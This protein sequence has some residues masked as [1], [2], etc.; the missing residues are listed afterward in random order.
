MYLAVPSQKTQEKPKKKKREEHRAISVPEPEPTAK[1]DPPKPKDK[2]ANR[3]VMAEIG[4]A[5]TES[6]AKKRRKRA[7][8]RDT[9]KEYYDAFRANKS[10][11]FGVEATIPGEG[12]NALVNDT[13]FVTPAAQSSDLKERIVKEDGVASLAKSDGITRTPAIPRKRVLDIATVEA[14]SSR[15]L[16]DYVRKM[17]NMKKIK[18]PKAKN[19]EAIPDTAEDQVPM[20]AQKETLR[21]EI[22]NA[23]AVPTFTVRVPHTNPRLNSEAASPIRKRKNLSSPAQGAEELIEPTPF[24]TVRKKAK[25]ASPSQK[26]GM[27]EAVIWDLIDHNPNN[28]SLIKKL[29]RILPADSENRPERF[30]YTVGSPKVTAEKPAGSDSSGTE[31]GN[32]NGDPKARKKRPLSRTLNNPA[33]EALARENVIVMP[34]PY[35]LLERVRNANPSSGSGK[36]FISMVRR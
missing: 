15:I 30:I 5:A 17:A 12:Q 28:P 26:R 14:E 4:A 1:P 11:F 27:A 25:L 23:R 7:P 8:R 13:I 2:K 10:G 36:K 18:V 3:P 19:G 35:N 6:S 20:I 21:Q 16:G 32:P 22:P 34:Q 29:K 24:P 31:K 9:K 33:G